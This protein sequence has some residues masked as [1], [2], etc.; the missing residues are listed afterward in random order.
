MDATAFLL[1][2]QSLQQHL[3]SPCPTTDSCELVQCFL[4]K[5]EGLCEGFKSFA[6]INRTVLQLSTFVAKLSFHHRWTVL[7][8]F[9][10]KLHR[11]FLICLVR[12][13][14]HHKLALVDT[15]HLWHNN[16]GQQH[17]T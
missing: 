16:S 15:P 4:Q 9:F 14:H 10:S 5:I 13:A 8:I 3:T 12:F 2:P 17:Q 7:D 11:L 6:T 1:N